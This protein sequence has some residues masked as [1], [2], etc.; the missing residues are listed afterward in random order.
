MKIDINKEKYKE[1]FV[2]LTLNV[3]SEWRALRVYGG[4]LDKI[5]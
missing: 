5:C 1:T 2:L 3:I 4:W